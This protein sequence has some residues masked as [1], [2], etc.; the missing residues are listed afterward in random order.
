MLVAIIRLVL[1]LLGVVA[2]VFFYCFGW[3]GIRILSLFTSNLAYHLKKRFKDII[4]AEVK[5]LN[6]QMPEWQTNEKIVK[7]TFSRHYSRHLETLFL[8]ALNKDRLDGLVYASGLEH[9]EKAISQG[10]GVILLLSHFGSFLLPLPYLG[11]RGY[12]VCQITGRQNHE[13]IINDR[14]WPRVVNEEIWRWRKKEADKLPVNFIE[15]G[16]FLRPVYKALNDN[17]IVAI[18][19]DGRESSKWENVGFLGGSEHF[20]PGP[21]ELARR[22]GAVIIPTFVVKETHKRHK[23]IFEKQFE[24][25]SNTLIEKANHIDTAGYA[26]KLGEYIKK[27]PCHF[28]VH[29]PY[30]RKPFM[31]K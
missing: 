28:L 8:G 19:F 9:I 26:H 3:S 27:W 21:F 15:V 1:F 30:I 24:M 16:T 6:K 18:A 25:S 31:L 2:Y 10:N 12:N 13:A 23:I 7:R 11:F 4:S 20:S 5:R 17:C 29:F 14:I 22:T